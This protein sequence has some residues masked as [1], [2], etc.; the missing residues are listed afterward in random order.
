M[1]SNSKNNNKK[2]KDGFFVLTS[3]KVQESVNMYD[4]VIN[5]TSA[6]GASLG[7]G[8]V[9][10]MRYEKPVVFQ[11]R[12]NSID[13]VMLEE[14]AYIV[15]DDP[16]L[17]LEKRIE[18]YEETLREIAEKLIVARTIKDEKEEKEL[19][20]QRRILFKNLENLKEQYKSQN[21]DTKLTNV[22]TQIMNL[23]KKIKKMIRKQIRLFFRHS[24]FI[25]NFTPLVRSMTVR[26]TLGRLDKINKSVDQ[27]VKMKVPFGEQEE[28]YQTLVNHLSRATALHSQIQRELIG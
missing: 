12:L 22:F 26:E 10:E 4:K 20:K 6:L 17:K 18:S 5:M 13:S 19:L 1:D 2:K 23:P 21:L 28:R 25:R 15:L 27:L 11:K 7:D 9:D 8:Q 24:K 3:H 16:D 14:S